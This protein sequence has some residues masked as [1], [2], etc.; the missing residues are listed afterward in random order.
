MYVAARQTEAR[1]R[2]GEEGRAFS[3]SSSAS[4]S[5]LVPVSANDTNHRRSQNEKSEVAKNG[6][7]QKWT[8]EVNDHISGF[9]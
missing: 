6:R 1:R 8:S 2:R 9:I 3:I 4:V 5:G 7:V